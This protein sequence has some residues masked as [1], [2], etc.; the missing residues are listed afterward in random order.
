MGSMNIFED[1]VASMFSLGLQ[2]QLYGFLG[3]AQRLLDGKTIGDAV[4]VVRKQNRS[5]PA[6]YSPACRVIWENVPAGISE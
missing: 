3:V 1:W 6:L 5:N 2:M 4:E